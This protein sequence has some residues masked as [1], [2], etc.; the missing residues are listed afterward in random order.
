MTNKEFWKSI[1]TII[2]NGFDKDGMI[3]LEDYAEQFFNKQLLFKRYSPSEQHGCATGGS[4]HVVA[5][6]LAGAETPTNQLTAPEGSFKRDCQRAEAQAA[7][8][9]QWAKTIGCWVDGVDKDFE[10]TFGE[11]LAEGGEAHVSC[12]AASG[13]VP[14]S[15]APWRSTRP[16]SCST[17]RSQASIRSLSKTSRASSLR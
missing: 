8:I 11:Q 13:D 7:V 3:K 5:S 2:N 14:K 9:E 4:F 6:I 17:N 10:Q 12:R 15:R 16:S 1:S